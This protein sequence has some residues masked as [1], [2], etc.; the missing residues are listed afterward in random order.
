MTHLLDRI[1]QDLRYGWR[2]LRR[3]PGFTVVAIVTLALGIG[4]NTAFFGLVDA[5]VFRPTAVARLD[6]VFRLTLRDPADPS[7]PL[8]L[9]LGDAQGLERTPPLSVAA[10]TSVSQSSN[11]SLIQTAGRAEYVLGER[12]SAGYARVFDLSAQAGRWIS[13]DDDAGRGDDVVVISDRLWR[14]WFR[15]DPAIVGRA[16]LM[17]GTPHRVIGV[18]PPGFRGIQTGFV[19]TEIWRPLLRPIL[20]PDRPDAPTLLAQQRSELTFI[21]TRPGASPTEVTGEV[22]AVLTGQPDPDPV[23]ATLALQPGAEALRISQLVALAAGILVFSGLVFLAACANLANMLYA[24]GAD[25]AGEIAVRLS[26]G[27]R[28]RNVFGLFLAETAIIALIAALAGLVLAIGATS[29]FSAAFPTFRL[30]RNLGVT[31]DLTPDY[32]VFLY[33]FGAGTLAAFVVGLL[34]AWRSSR[35][36]ILRAIGGGTTTHVVSS[37]RRGLPISFVSV[38]ITVAVLLLIGA[39]LF[40]ENTRPLL[41]RRIHYDTANLAA[42][43]IRWSPAESGVRLQDMTREEQLQHLQEQRATYAARREAYFSTLLAR[44]GALPGVEAAAFTDALPG[45]TAPAPQSAKAILQAPSRLDSPAGLPRR[46]DGSWLR[47]SPGFL[48]TIGVRLVRGRGI[49]PTDDRAGALWPNEDPIGR[50][51]NCCRFDYQAI[52]VVGVV[53]DFV[54]SS[55]RSPATRHANFALLPAA[56]A[57][58]EERFVIIRAANPAGQ[59]EALRATIHELAPHVPVFDAGPVDELLLA[60]VALER[61][62]R[63]LTM[64]L[65]LLALGIAMLGVYGVVGYFVSRRTRE[66]G[67]RLALGAVPS[68][69]L[70]LVVDYAVHVILIGLL[71]GVLLAS[72]GTRLFEHQLFGVMPNGI[73][74]WV[75]APL[76]MLAAG[77]AAGLV[78]ARRAARVDPNVTLREL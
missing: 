53:E 7:R 5:V 68:Q 23:A 75:V 19:P 20:P 24:R 48:D 29:A 58:D 77:I 61:A 45:G 27:A 39:G 4:A 33:A 38:Q 54:S 35:V 57:G 67:L 52:Q 41:D 16:T 55:D 64:S 14:R 44:V 49:W 63:V 30:A 11:A 28:A 36:S 42:A 32:R 56:Q 51:L 25:R 12:V 10:V 1:V 46:V 18:A 37:R 76:L 13:G 43:R 9:R 72:L 15:A 59:V 26:L 62:Q 40:F 31:I 22:A 65:G 21:R 3:T 17:I 8:L 71:P 66:F 60:G 2:G 47:V 73:T 34:T 6:Q 78:P 50:T 70:K 74:M 69:I